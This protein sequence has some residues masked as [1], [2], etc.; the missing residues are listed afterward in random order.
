MN[1]RSVLLLLATLVA[2]VGTALVVVYVRSADNRAQEQFD[3][4]EVLRATQT[5]EAGESIEAATSAGKIASQAVP[6]NQVLDGAMQSVDAL[7]GEVAV[8]DIYAGEQIVPAKFGGQPEGETL[9]IP[10]GMVAI[11]VEL[12]D[13]YRVA[14]FVNPGSE[15]AIY[16]LPTSPDSGAATPGAAQPG[17]P[18]RVRVLL[19]RV[20]VLGVGST[21]TTTTRKSVDESGQQTTSEVPQTLLT[22]AVNQQDAERVLYAEDEVVDHGEVAFAL[23]TDKSKVEYTRGVGPDNIYVK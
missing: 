7:K 8:T 5:I 9:A 12:S 13:P 23:L 2:L 10:D 3:T 4:V 17:V 20:L 6:K 14:G 16:Y 19:K 21:S 11:S 18:D 15:V 1:R 22:I